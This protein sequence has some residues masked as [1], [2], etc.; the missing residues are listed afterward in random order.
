VKI[1]R[2][3]QV[4]WPFWAYHPIEQSQIEKGEVYM[5]MNEQDLRLHGRVSMTTA[6]RSLSVCVIVLLWL[7]ESIAQSP[8]NAWRSA[9]PGAPVSTVIVDPYDPNIIYAGG[10]R[11]VFKSL[12]NGVS[13]IRLSLGAAT[14]LSVDPANP[15][16]IFAANNGVYKSIDGGSTWSRLA[17][18]TA[19]KV[20]VSANDPNFVV[21][22][23]DANNTYVSNNGGVS[24]E[25]RTFPGTSGLGFDGHSIEIDPKNPNNIY[26]YY[27]DYESIFLRR[28][29]NG[30][31]SW[32]PFDYPCL[33]PGCPPGPGSYII[34]HTTSFK[35][36]PRDSNIV[37][38]SA[39]NS[40]YC[41][42]WSLFK[43]TDGGANWIPIAAMFVSH[44]M[45]VSP[46]ETGVI[47]A[48]RNDWH[49]PTP[50]MMFRSL[51]EGTT[52]SA[53][54]EGLPGGASDLAFDRS[55]SYLHAATAAGVF[56]VRL[57]PTYKLSGSVLTPAGHPLRNATVSI[58]DTN[59]VRHAATTSSFGRYTFSDIRVDTTYTVSVASRRY[60]FA[61]Q[62]VTV[63]GD[64]TNIDLVGQE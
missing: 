37:Y 15:N 50:L 1:R 43:S 64:L 28:S 26:T 53:F 58:T 35:V 23:D 42:D 40:W 46:R 54:N 9:G 32:V 41:R 6:A 52:W 51:N 63:N 2:A 48:V 22:A 56:S 12:D 55:A 14:D 16:T 27:V 21:A 25:T 60:R 20:Q 13:W 62:T 24:W 11:G 45:A 47:Y 57:R 36:D 49:Y 19:S 59:G 61:S 39:C 7:G 34:S 17:P 4:L 3:L 29:N 30:G 33:I 31:A 44:T 8:L 10:S 38:A 18:Q 5:L